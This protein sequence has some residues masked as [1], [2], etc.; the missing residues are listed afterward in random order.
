MKHLFNTAWL[1]P[2]DLLGCAICMASRLPLNL[3]NSYISTILVLS[4]DFRHS[5][6]GM[7][8]LPFSLWVRLNFGD[9]Q[10]GHTER[11]RTYLP[12]SL[13]TRSNRSYKPRS[14]CGPRRITLR[15]CSSSCGG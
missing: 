10:R 2:I 9:F 11:Q 8:S 3:W 12:V 13:F 1:M 7:V 5:C 15:E 4:P 6:H 14:N